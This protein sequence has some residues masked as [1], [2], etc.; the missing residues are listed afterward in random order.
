MDLKKFI[1]DIPDF[2]KPGIIF[3]DLTPLLKDRDAFA[4][5][6]DHLARH[7]QGT[8]LTAI[9]GI[10]SRGFI[11]G[12]ALALTLRTGFLPLRKPGKLPYKTIRQEYSLEYGTD[13][14]EI[15]QDAIAP[16]DRILLVDDLLATGGTARAG[17]E[18]I[19]RLGGELAGIAFLIELAF[20]KGRERLAGEQVFSLLTF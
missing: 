16:G 14:I 12:S 17:A 2:P 5:A 6:I 1:R 3:K 7:Y 11:I 8:R 10:E 15:H 13:A 9:A 20:L 19:R 18:L 4:T